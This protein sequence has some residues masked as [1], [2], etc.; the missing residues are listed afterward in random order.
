M[1]ANGLVQIEGNY[2][3]SSAV[4][5][6]TAIITFPEWCKR[7]GFNMA[8]PC[9]NGSWS[10][11]PLYYDVPSNTLA[12]PNTITANTQLYIPAI[13]WQVNL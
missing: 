3:V 6:Y 10:T 12:C 5:P 13:T 9:Y 4:S 11:V 7:S 1:C 2:I 8:V